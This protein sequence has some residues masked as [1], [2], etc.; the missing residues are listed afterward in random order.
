M[1]PPPR[2]ISVFACLLVLPLGIYVV[3][4]A[5]ETNATKQRTASLPDQTYMPVVIGQDFE[6][7]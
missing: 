5:Q 1:T 7:K 2:R 6:A 4:K 3:V